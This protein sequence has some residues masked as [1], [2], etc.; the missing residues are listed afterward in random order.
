MGR[1]GT[2]TD[3]C[4]LYDPAHPPEPEV[5][6]VWLGVD[7]PDQ[8]RIVGD[9]TIETRHIGR[10]AITV[11]GT[12]PTQRRRIFDSARWRVGVDANGCPPRPRRPGG[13]SREGI[14][15]VG[16]TSLCVYDDNGRR[17]A[18]ARLATRAGRRFVAAFEKA[19]P[20]PTPRSCVAWMDQGPVEVIITHTDRRTGQRAHARFAVY[21]GAVTGPMGTTVPLTPA[22]VRPWAHPLVRGFVPNLGS[23]RVARFF[24][25]SIG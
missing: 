12:N 8:S 6:Y 1:P 14:G 20:G 17:F 2:R 15:E 24:R 3:V 16:S 23:R 11:A 21:C 13:V 25:P 7:L 4:S 22:L 18:S 5:P 19:R 9:Y 10:V